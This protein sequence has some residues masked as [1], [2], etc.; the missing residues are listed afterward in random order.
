MKIER[1]LKIIWGFV[2]FYFVFVDDDT[3]GIMK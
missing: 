1:R 3:I 2:D